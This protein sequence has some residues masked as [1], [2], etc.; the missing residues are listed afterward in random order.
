MIVGYAPGAYDL[1]HVGHLAL[2]RRARA[3]CDVLVAGV[4]TDALVV[5]VKAHRPVI[6]FPER[7]AIVRAIRCVDV[8]VADD[9]VDKTEVWRTVRF[10]VLFK[11]TDW[12]GSD[13]ARRLETALADVG[14]RVVYL[15]YTEHTSSTLLRSTI[16]RLS[17]PSP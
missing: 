16:T 14:A 8:A 10:D 1:F 5:Q 15:P 12:Q 2:L 4:A 17:G 13:R 3:R 11:G 7:L 6:P 9:A